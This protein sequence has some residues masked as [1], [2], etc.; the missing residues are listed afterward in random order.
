MRL[1]LD[2]PVISVVNINL[3]KS[4]AYHLSQ[5]WLSSQGVHSLM[6]STQFTQLFLIHTI[7]PCTLLRPV[8]STS[9][10]TIFIH[11]KNYFSYNSFT[12]F[13]LVMVKALLLK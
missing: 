3:P 1:I 11:E 6:F 9:K 2:D 5:N 8:K 10:V 7:I 12:K 13:Q 4:S